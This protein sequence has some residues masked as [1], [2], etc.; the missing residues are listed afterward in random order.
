MSTE[1]KEGNSKDEWYSDRHKLF[2]LIDSMKSDDIKKSLLLHTITA[3]NISTQEITDILSGTSNKNKTRINNKNFELYRLSFTI[4][5]AIS[6]GRYNFDQDFNLD[7]CQIIATY[8]LSYY[9]YI[10][11]NGIS[12]NNNDGFYDSF[13]AKT[14]KLTLELK[15]KS[16]KCLISGNPLIIGLR[17][18]RVNHSIISL[19]VNRDLGSI[20]TWTAKKHY[21]TVKN[22][23]FKDK[24]KWYHIAISIDDINHTQNLYVDGELMSVVDVRGLGSQYT[25]EYKMDMDVVE[26]DICIGGY[27]ILPQ[28]LDENMS[29]YVKD[30]RIWNVSR[31]QIEINEFK[32]KALIGNEE[33]LVGNWIYGSYDQSSKT[34]DK[35]M[36]NLTKHS[37]FVY[38]T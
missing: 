16:I 35:R 6:N 22:N 33:G 20:E 9:I 4:N 7:L 14:K 19:H 12:V 21:R 31:N 1:K 10:K 23:I 25:D 17:N 37:E 11:Q 15:I 29:C 2:N 24:N 8:I 5:D 3:K 38:E 28:N 18:K 36:I 27:P 13:I 30:I 26:Q 32:D 34:N